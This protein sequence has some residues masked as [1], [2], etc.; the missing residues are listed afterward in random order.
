MHSCPDVEDHNM[1]HSGCINC[2]FSG[3]S[4]SIICKD[5]FEL[6]IYISLYCLIILLTA[7]FFEQ[8]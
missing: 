2:C 6:P 5:E 7:L 4:M 3:D 8:K 1:F